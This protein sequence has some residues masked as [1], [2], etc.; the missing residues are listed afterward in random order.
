MG[1]KSTQTQTSQSQ[2]SPWEAAQPALQNILGQLNGQLGNT[3]LTG[4]ETNAL[5]SLAGAGNNPFANDISNYAKLMFSGGG[6][7][8][9]A[10]RLSY[11]TLKC[12]NGFHAAHTP[13]A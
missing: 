3:N 11:V 13:P 4:T 1:G 5:N 9:E 10:G 12:V 8:N 6:A 2:T 7:S